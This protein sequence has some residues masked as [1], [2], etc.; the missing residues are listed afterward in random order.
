[1]LSTILPVAFDVPGGAA[2]KSHQAAGEDVADLLQVRREVS[3]DGDLLHGGSSW[4]T[5]DQEGQ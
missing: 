2:A 3:V 4:Q 5:A 1:M